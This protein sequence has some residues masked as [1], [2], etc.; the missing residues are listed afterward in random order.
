MTNQQT[1]KN[2][3][4]NDLRCGMLMSVRVNCNYIT[5]LYADWDCKGGELDFIGE[6]KYE[7]KCYE[8]FWENYNKKA[9]YYFENNKH[10]EEQLIYL[11][12]EHL[13]DWK[14]NFVW[15]L[16][17]EEEEIAEQQEEVSFWDR[18]KFIGEEEEDKCFKCDKTLEEDEGW[19]LENCKCEGGKGCEK[20][21]CKQLDREDCE[22]CGDIGIE[23]EWSEKI[24]LMCCEE[25]REE[26][27]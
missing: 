14:D 26:E 2:Y 20:E 21:P 5:S 6:E 23:V 13:E 16:E 7:A 4:N 22:E 24:G 11:F 17:E 1:N 9:T 12:E 19:E 3:N 25:C 10:R 15:K 8:A 27:E 18:V